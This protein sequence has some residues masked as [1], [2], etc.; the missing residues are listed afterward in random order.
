MVIKIVE[1][2]VLCNPNVGMLF[3][4]ISLHVH[5]MNNDDRF[6]AL[7]HAEILYQEEE[8]DGD[9]GRREGRSV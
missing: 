8:E 5:H 3:S 2:K 1:R 4:L 6:I 9:D 7:A